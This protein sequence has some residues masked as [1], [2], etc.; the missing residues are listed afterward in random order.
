M[1]KYPSYFILC[2]YFVYL[3][4]E[5]YARI[6]LFSS[7]KKKTKQNETKRNEYTRGREKNTKRSN[8]R[9]AHRARKY[10][11]REE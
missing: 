7:K 5:M 10:C 6:G 9:R 1:Y 8:I 4:V 2:R 11:E 3:S